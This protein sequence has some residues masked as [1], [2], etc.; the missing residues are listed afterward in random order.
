MDLKIKEEMEFSSMKVI[1][2]MDFFLTVSLD[3]FGGLSIVPFRLYYGLN[4]FENE[5][6]MALEGGIWL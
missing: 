3:F 4:C 2:C 1:G 5:L 6:F